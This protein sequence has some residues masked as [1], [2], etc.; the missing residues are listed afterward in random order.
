M[1]P[2]YGVG[3][4]LAIYEAYHKIT[5]G[6]KHARTDY[7]FFVEQLAGFVRSIEAV[8]QNLGS[9]DEMN[10]MF[11]KTIED[12]IDFIKKHKPLSEDFR[13][14]RRNLETFYEKWTWAAE[15]GN[16]LDLR[17]RLDYFV[18]SA[19]LRAVPSIM[20]GKSCHW[21]QISKLSLATY[22]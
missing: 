19:L 4:V 1:L 16:L 6:A 20:Y 21:H 2:G 8:E 11:K 10:S 12:C 13:K 14:G 15:A 18:Q 7:N 3:D 22:S 9:F 5:Q 17:Q